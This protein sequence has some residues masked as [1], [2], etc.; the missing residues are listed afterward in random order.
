MAP[1]QFY[2][3]FPCHPDKMGD[4]YVPRMTQEIQT[5][6]QRRSRRGHLLWRSALQFN[7]YVEC[8]HKLSV[9]CNIMH[10]ICQACSHIHSLSPTNSHTNTHPA[11]QSLVKD[12]LPPRQTSFYSKAV[13]ASNW[14]L[15]YQHTALQPG[16][17]SLLFV[18]GL[19]CI[20][21]WY[22]FTGFMCL[23]SFCEH[24]CAVIRLFICVH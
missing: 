17:I 19:Q 24:V 1:T 9:I 2:L 10:V 23:A 21:L 8:W 15:S 13:T 20:I 16:N 6:T 3:V 14:Y 18:S 11:S 12:M 5:D 4:I 7:S 22:A